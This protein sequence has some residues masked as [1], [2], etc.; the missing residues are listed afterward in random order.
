VFLTF[1]LCI[2]PSSPLHLPA[3]SC[4]FHHAL[5]AVCHSLSSCL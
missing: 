1:K 5:P 3:F 2:T 4:I